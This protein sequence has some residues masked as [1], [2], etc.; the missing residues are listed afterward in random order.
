MRV[1]WLAGLGLVAAIGAAPVPA[2]AADRFAL[3]ISGVSGSPEY[4][5]THA[6]RRDELVA[7]LVGPLRVPKENVVVLKEGP[8]DAP[9]AASSERV[10]AA[11]RSLAPRMTAED[12]LLVVLLGHGSD[13]GTD[14]KFNLVGPDLGAAEFAKLLQPIRAR[15]VF[16]NTTAS[17]SAFVSDLAGPGRIVITATDTPAQRYDT[18]FGEYFGPAFTAPDADLDKDGRVSVGE[19]FAFASLRVKEYYADRGQLATERAVLDDT[20]DGAGKQAGAVGP[21]GAVASRTFFDL[22]PEVA[23]SNDA[24]MSELLARRDSLEGALEELRRKKEFMPA[25]DYARELERLLVDLA[26]LS[27]DIRARS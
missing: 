2:S 7:A 23:A 20:G 21:D 19:A 14:A 27:R 11:F 12:V 22:G 18:V 15:V 9:D 24:A 25:G 1:W 13:D 4:A 5:E 3:I 16:V 6:K 10:A 17:S 8:R 26:R